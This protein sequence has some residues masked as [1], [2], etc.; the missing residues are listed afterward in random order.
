MSFTGF[1]TETL[2]FLEGIAENNNKE[3]FTANRSGYDAAVEAA[4]ELV[5]ECGP[6]LREISPTIN[7][8]PRIGA[9]LPRINRDTRFSHDKRPYKDHLDLWFW[10]GEK[11]GWDQ[12][13]FFLRITSEAL[14]VATGMMHIEPPQLPAFRDA[15][16]A[17]ASGE[18]LVGAIAQINAIGPYQT[19]YP[20]RKTVPRGYDK[21]SPRA[22]YLLYE[23]LWAHLQLPA[24]DALRPDFAEIALRAWRDMSPIVFWLLDE[25]TAPAD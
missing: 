19:G 1:P 12:P 21:S 7:F 6:R 24:T 22:E 11:K 18:R 15:V 13:G 25:V 23:S 4:K 2:A 3:W 17:D 16:V 9:S 14:W 20:K 8:E 5:A 10:H